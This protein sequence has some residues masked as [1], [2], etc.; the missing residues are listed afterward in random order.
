MFKD[1]IQKIGFTRLILIGVA[2][3]VIVICSVNSGNTTTE[4]S[5]DETA[6]TAQAETETLYELEERLEMRL[7]QLL[8][9]VDG[10]GSVR[11]MVI[12]KS[13]VGEEILKD[14][15]LSKD[16]VTESDS[17]GGT[18]QSVSF[19]QSEETIME[20]AQDEDLPYVLRAL[21][22]E[23]AGIAIV[24]EGGDKAEVV[25]KLTEMTS[26]LFA[27]DVTQVSVLDMK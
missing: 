20:T 6:Q 14:S 5:K 8:S 1:V 25:C 16:E 27:I 19:S 13:G 26:A 17:S 12:L 11:V 22:P 15:I 21:A 9:Q 2:G 10:V 24:A 3:A 18:R 4:S 23:V 7:T